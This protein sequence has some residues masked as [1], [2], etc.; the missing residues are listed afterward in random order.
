MMFSVISS[1]SKVLTFVCECVCVCVCVC[2]RRCE[3]V[4]GC[5]CVCV[6]VCGCERERVAEVEEQ[7]GAK[8][9]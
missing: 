4:Y 1:D 8:V 3:C 5:V 9:L 7:M 6:W 2:A